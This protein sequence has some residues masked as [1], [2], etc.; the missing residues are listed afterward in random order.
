MVVAASARA[1]WASAVALVLIATAVPICPNE[2]V[3]P[4]PLLSAPIVV[5]VT[6]IVPLLP[7][8]FAVTVPLPRSPEPAEAGRRGID[9]VTGIWS[10]SAGMARTEE[11]RTEG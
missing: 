2:M 6:V 11:S 3:S 4:A 5:D 7:M 10:R 9:A 1:G 8:T